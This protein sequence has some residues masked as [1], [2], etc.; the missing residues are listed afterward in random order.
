MRDRLLGRARRV[1]SEPVGSVVRQVRGASGPC[2][3]G[4]VARRVSG[5]SRRRGGATA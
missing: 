1:G 3:V 2:C 4:S 5:S